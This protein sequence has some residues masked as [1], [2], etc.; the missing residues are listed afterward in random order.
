[1]Q[2]LKDLSFENPN[3][4]AH[5]VEEPTEKPDVGINVQVNARMLTEG[6]FEVVLE[7]NVNAKIGNEV[8]FI[9]QLQYAAIVSLKIDKQDETAVRKALL[10]ECPHL[11]FP[12]ARNIIAET[13]MNSGFQPL[14][15]QPV[16]FSKLSQMAVKNS[17]ADGSGPNEQVH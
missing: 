16:D 12:F 6:M 17:V 1:M 9:C 2:Y 8:L 3:P 10:E 15:L 7:I 4:L 11:I 14:L 13:T 5:A